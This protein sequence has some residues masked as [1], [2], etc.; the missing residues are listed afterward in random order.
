MAQLRLL[1]K[2]KKSV[3]IELSKSITYIGYH[4][5]YNGFIH[6]SKDYLQNTIE[7]IY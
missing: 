2:F 1:R 3:N 6:N 4:K 7:K 5:K